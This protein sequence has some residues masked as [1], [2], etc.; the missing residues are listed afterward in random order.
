MKFKAWIPITPK[1]WLILCS[2]LLFTTGCA[3]DRD[4]FETVEY[5]PSSRVTP[6]LPRLTF[7]RVEPDRTVVMTYT[8]NK[9]HE[10][11]AK[12]GQELQFADGQRASMYRVV[13]ASP[14]TQGVVL[15][16]MVHMAG[17]V[18]HF[19]DK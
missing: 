7:E 2:A 17:N 8:T 5:S 11:C 6:K 4:R 19:G 12:P 1:Q 16:Y 9:A 3:S 15:A 18:C 14:K 10:V 13:S